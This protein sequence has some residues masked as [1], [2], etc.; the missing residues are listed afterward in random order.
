MPNVSRNVISSTAFGRQYSCL[1]SCGHTV[2]CPGVHVR[3]SLFSQRA[4]LTATCNQCSK[5]AS[6]V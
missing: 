6:D 2:V 1:L 4:P 3:G 5:G